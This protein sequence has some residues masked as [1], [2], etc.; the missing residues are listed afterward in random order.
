M[1]FSN[2]VRNE[3]A[4]V[5]PEKECCCQAELSALLTSG[6]TVV[7]FEEDGYSLQVRVENA[8][9]ARKIFKLFK[10]NGLQSTV[11][12]GNRKRF[13]KTKIY[14]VATHFSADNLS[15]LQELHLIEDNNNRR[16]F[17]SHLTR[18]TCCKRC[19]LR[20]V[21][22]SR[23]FVNRPEND[24]H[25][26]LVFTGEKLA[27]HVQKL[28]AHFDIEARIFER[29]NNLVVY[30]KESEKI[31]DFLR[32]VGASRALLEF[33]N[34]R[35]IKSMRNTVNRQVNC[36][37]ANLAKTIDASVRQIDLINRAMKKE[38]WKN[39]P[40]Q[41]KEL[42]LLRIEYPDYTLKELGELTQPPLSKSGVAYRMRR[43]EK[44]AEDI[45]G[46]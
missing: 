3:L 8:A 13:G 12:I 19:F 9:T 20:G 1:S 35:I 22:L 32:V 4:R 11:R 16:Q 24:Y 25:L 34:V 21:F 39:L 33:E 28:L 41:F 45:I 46:I 10:R 27:V 6:S 14:E 5:M 29:K 26:E 43:L 15:I 2:D 18:K 23:G 7:E 37:T 44:M 17:R 38:G 42:A 31:G 30:V 40:P 36:E